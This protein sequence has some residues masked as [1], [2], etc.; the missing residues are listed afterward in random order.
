MLS[1]AVTFLIIALIAATIAFGG[2]TGASIVLHKL[3]FWVFIVLFVVA[4]VCHI[5]ARRRPPAPPA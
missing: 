1:L 3:I 5:I 4:L 2:F